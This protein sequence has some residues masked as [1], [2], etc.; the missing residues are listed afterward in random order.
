MLLNVFVCGGRW[1]LDVG[2]PVSVQGEGRDTKAYNQK[3]KVNK[4][5]DTK[6][7]R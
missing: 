4:E 7:K 5:D 2:L 3:G 6:V 1:L